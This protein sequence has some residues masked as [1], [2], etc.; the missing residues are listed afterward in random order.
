M[1]QTNPINLDVFVR[2]IQSSIVRP[3]RRTERERDPS[4]L[5]TSNSCKQSLTFTIEIGGFLLE[6]RSNYA[7][8]RKKHF[9]R[10]V[11]PKCKSMHMKQIDAKLNRRRKDILSMILISIDKVV[12]CLHQEAVGVLNRSLAFCKTSKPSKQIFISRERDET[13]WRRKERNMSEENRLDKE[14]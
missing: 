6:N 10:R 4:C 13:T 8:T 2:C 1:N 7:S 3:Y 12:L 14:S 9:K 11:L 5:S